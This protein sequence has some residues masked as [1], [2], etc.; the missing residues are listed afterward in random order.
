MADRSNQG[1]LTDAEN[2]RIFR[3]EILPDYLP[4]GELGEA[5]LYAPELQIVNQNSAITAANDLRQRTQAYLGRDGLNPQTPRVD[6]RGLAALAGDPV[7]LADQLDHDLLYGRMSAPMHDTLVR[8]LGRLP[9]D[10]AYA[11]VTAAVHLVPLAGLPILPAYS[12]ECAWPAA[13]AV[14]A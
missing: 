12:R 10:N 14:S 3:S 11:R 5:R 9:A 8:M 4:P 13:W 7:A 2:E 1:R 6:L